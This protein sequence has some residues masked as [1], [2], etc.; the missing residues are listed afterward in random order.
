ML[1]AKCIILRY[2]YEGWNFYFPLDALYV[3][4]LIQS[5]TYR[6]SNGIQSLITRILCI[7]L[8][9]IRIEYF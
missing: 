8:V 7:L 1:Y 5:E 3:F 4:G 2:V 9:Y 6:A